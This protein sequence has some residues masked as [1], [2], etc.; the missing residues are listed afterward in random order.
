ML[1]RWIIGSVAVCGACLPTVAAGPQPIDALGAVVRVEFD[2]FDVPLIRAE[3]FEDGAVALGYLH[4]Q[5]RL[6]QMDLIRRRASGRLSE[7]IGPDTIGSD[8]AVRV[9]G[10]DGVAADVV[11]SL[12][13]RHRRLLEAYR[14]GV[15]A[16]IAAMAAPPLEY[17]LLGVAPEPWSLEDSI[18]V[19]LDMTLLLRSGDQEDRVLAGMRDA[20]APKWWSFWRRVRR[21]SMRRSMRPPTIR[22]GGI[23]RCRCPGPRCSLFRRWTAPRSN[24]CA[25]RVNS[26]SWARTVGRSLVRGRRTAGPSSPMTCTCR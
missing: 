23:G 25:W 24:W 13:E 11:A 2:A 14:D 1:G 19:M 6:V 9:Y 22:P 8:R 3:R 26:R 18:L 16:G 12:P 17:T 5:E 20:L 21:G 15:N 10:F 7:I 4:A